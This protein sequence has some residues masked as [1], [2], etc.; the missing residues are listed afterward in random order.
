MIELIQNH[1]YLAR[2]IA[3]CAVAIVGL[4]WLIWSDGHE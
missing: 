2:A 4:G 1:A 3:G